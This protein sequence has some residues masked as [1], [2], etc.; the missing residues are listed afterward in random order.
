MGIMLGYH[1]GDVGN[2]ETSLLG[3][4]EQ[5][6]EITKYKKKIGQDSQMPASVKDILFGHGWHLW[7]E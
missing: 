6:E 3:Q 1:R 2:G 5:K 7:A 4:R